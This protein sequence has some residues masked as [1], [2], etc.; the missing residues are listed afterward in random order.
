M[1]ITAFGRA[2]NPRTGRSPDVVAC[3]VCGADRGAPCLSPK[4]EAAA[5]PHS[6]RVRRAGNI[7][8]GVTP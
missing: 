3:P 1:L 2:A 7:A 5:K 8:P 4:G 6:K